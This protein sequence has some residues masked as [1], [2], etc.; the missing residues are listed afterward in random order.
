MKLGLA[1]SKLGSE[2]ADSSRGDGRRWFWSQWKD[3][4]GARA[5]SE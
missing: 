4:A 2:E 5:A 1:A 3:V